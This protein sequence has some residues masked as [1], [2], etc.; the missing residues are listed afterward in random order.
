M[1]KKF[2]TTLVYGIFFYG[3]KRPGYH[4]SIRIKSLEIGFPLSNNL[5]IYVSRVDSTVW[6]TDGTLTGTFQLSPE[7]KYFGC[8][9]G[10]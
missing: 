2:N 9:G 6:V 3:T 1:K 10:V 8:I 5:A 7:I 4:K